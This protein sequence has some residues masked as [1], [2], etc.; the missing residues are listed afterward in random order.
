MEQHSGTAASP[1]VAIAQALMK[2]PPVLLLDEPFGA[3]DPGT[4][5]VISDGMRILFCGTAAEFPYRANK[6]M[7]VATD[8]PLGTVPVEP[9]SLGGLKGRF[10]STSQ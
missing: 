6:E 5:Q 7:F 2:S 8:L 10:R 9:R 3:L 4:R 1:G